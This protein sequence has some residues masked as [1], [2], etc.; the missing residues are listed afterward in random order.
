MMPA[1]MTYPLIILLLLAAAVLEA[2]GDALVRSGLHAPELWPRAIRITSGGIVLLLYGCLV[3]APSW[4]FGRL[5]GAYVVF[6]FLVAQAISWVAF[7]HPPS[8]STML[9]GTLIIAG[10]VVVS[11]Q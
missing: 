8:A 6:F 3:N 1:P 2:G 10:G 5:I 9:G 11:W 7:H 4:D